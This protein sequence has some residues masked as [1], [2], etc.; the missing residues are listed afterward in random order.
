M[1]FVRHGRRDGNHAEIRDGLRLCGYKVLD[2][3]DLGK[4]VCDLLVCS[5]SKP[6]RWR[7][8][9]VKDPHQ[10][11]SARRLT[12]DE[13]KF[14]AEW[15]DAAKVVDTLEEALAALREAV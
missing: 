1:Y 4:G 7:L 8:L 2:L 15:G 13:A 10:P 12:P 9:E 5:K 6:R 3:A 14:H 11:P